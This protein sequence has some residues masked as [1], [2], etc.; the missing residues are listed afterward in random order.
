MR[1]SIRERVP[2]FELSLVLVAISILWAELRLHDLKLQADRDRGNTTNKF[3]L[4]EKAATN[5]HQESQRLQVKNEQMQQVFGELRSEF[6]NELKELEKNQTDQL[7]KLNDAFKIQEEYSS[8]AEHVES[9]ISAVQA[10]LTNYVNRQTPAESTAFER[11]R[12][13]FKN[14]IAKQ[15]ERNETERF[16]AKSQE[17]KE[18]VRAEQ[19]PG[20]NSALAITRDL[21]ALVEELTRAWTTY[22][23]QASR[24]IGGVGQPFTDKPALARMTN[25][26]LDA[27]QLFELARQARADGLTV[28]SFLE[29]QVQLQAQQKA[30]RQQLAIQ[31]FLTAQARLETNQA[32]SLGKL[33]NDLAVASLGTQPASSDYSS[34]LYP[35][36]AAQIGLGIFLVV[37]VYR[38]VVERLRLRLYQSDTEGKLAHFEKLAVWQ[39]HELKQPLTAITAWLWTLQQSLS[40]G[41]PEHSVATAIRKETD[42][43]D[44][45][46]KNS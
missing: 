1:L 4:L 12:G 39:A 6:T 36:I 33:T 40:E 29:P 17:L 38:K 26:R 45:I 37:S 27:E 23:A 7:F 15:K 46:V 28:K 16:P 11:K 42:R 14:W 43:L 21:G 19:P 13:E 10:A 9:G 32:L 41:T 35:L 20:T 18:W 44:Q 31:S 8:I 30:R 25:T 24:V 34:A 2:V 22:V 5:W 3:G